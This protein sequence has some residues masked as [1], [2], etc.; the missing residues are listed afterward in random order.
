MEMNE[1]EKRKK[2]RRIKEMPRQRDQVSLGNEAMGWESLCGKEIQKKFLNSKRQNLRCMQSQEPK[3][4]LK[5]EV[6][7]E[8]CERRSKKRQG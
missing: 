5:K 1:N 6:C 8:E 7:L 3:R 4:Q 2:V